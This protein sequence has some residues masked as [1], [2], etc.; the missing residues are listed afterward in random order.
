MVNKYPTHLFMLTFL[1]DAF[2]SVDG[3]R[4]YVSVT[5]LVNYL[6]ILFALQPKWPAGKI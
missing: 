3:D 1:C 5:E 2:N 4:K 6:H